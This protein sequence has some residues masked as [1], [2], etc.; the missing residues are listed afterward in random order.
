MEVKNVNGASGEACD[1]G[2]WMD[3]WRKFSLQQVPQFCP[4]ERCI[5]RPEVGAFV[6]KAP[7]NDDTWFVIPLCKE[8]SART[9]ETLTVAEH[10]ALVSVDVDQTCG[11]GRGRPESDLE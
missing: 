10:I 11:R 1:C 7:T 3:H 6:Q 4:E 2:T 9:G 8:C 5:R